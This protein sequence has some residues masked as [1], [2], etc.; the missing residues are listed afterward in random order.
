MTFVD[1]DRSGPGG[2]GEGKSNAAPRGDLEEGPDLTSPRTPVGSGG[3][4]RVPGRRLRLPLFLGLVGATMVWGA[5]LMLRIMGADGITLLEGVILVLFAVTFGWISVAFWT[6]IF[7]FILTVLGRDPLTLGRR[8]E[9]PDLWPGEAPPVSPDQLPLS[10]RTHTHRGRPLVTRTAVVMPAFNEDPGRVLQG[11]SAVIDSLERTGFGEHFHVFLL[12]DTTD[13]I[14]ADREESAWHAWRGGCRHP[15]RLFYRR[16]PSNEGRKAGNVAEFC[17]KWGDSYDFM[18]VLD[19]DSVMSGETLVALAR[20]MEANPDAGLL[21]T[22]PL[23]ARQ[24]ALFGRI[25]QFAGHLYTP[26][27][28]TGQ[29]FW[30]GDGANYW[31]HNAMLRLEPFA[32]HCEL[33]V[34]PGRPPMGG[35]ILSHDFVEAALL[36]RAGWR[37]YLLAGMRGSYEEVPETI[38]DFAIR[39]RRWAQGSLQHLRLL[40]MKGIRPV[41]RAHFLLGAMAYLSSVFWLLMLLAATSYVLYFHDR[42]GAQGGGSGPVFLV[43][44]IAPASVTLPSLLGITAALLFLPKLLGLAVALPGRRREFGGAVRLVASSLLEAAFA[45]LLAPLM[46]LLHSGFVAG[47]L[48]G[49]NVRW[50]AQV[51]GLRRVSWREAWSRSGGALAVGTVWCGATLAI[52]PGFFLWLTPIFAGILL[53]PALFRWTSSDRLGMVTRKRGV[54]LAPT[55]VSPSPE[56]TD[57]SRQLGVFSRTGS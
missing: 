38:T 37:S 31:G 32:R 5:I 18:V 52:S 55:E 50:N 26:M 36:G 44:R 33:P 13:P 49:L 48:G 6:G 8:S 11:L 7:G 14:L 25:L 29:A 42:A 28:A 9:L 1:A 46:M 23:P 12:S 56:L 27:F 19:A 54:F 22:V 39:D 53:S 17:R 20:T 35:E 57:A 21:Q 16:R 47:I 10:T 24:S 2:S 40:W 3:T 43:D 4:I 41:N 51:R 30:Q 45:V 15:D 34:L